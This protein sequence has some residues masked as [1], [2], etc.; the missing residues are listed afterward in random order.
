[1]PAYFTT[2]QRRMLGRQPPSSASYATGIATIGRKQNIP[3]LCCVIKPVGTHISGT[4][5]S[6]SSE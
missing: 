2:L 3:L 4:F 1:M 5:L 6:V